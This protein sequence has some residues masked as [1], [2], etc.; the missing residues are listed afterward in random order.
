MWIRYLNMIKYINTNVPIQVNLFRFDTRINI[1]SREHLRE[2]IEECDV[3]FLGCY[4][5]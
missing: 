3:N 5:P 1:N 4:I 2:D